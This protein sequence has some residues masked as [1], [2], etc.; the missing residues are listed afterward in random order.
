M[1]C[2]H[3]PHWPNRSTTCSRRLFDRTVVWIAT[4]IESVGIAIIVF[5]GLVATGLFL[6]R[7]SQTKRFT[8]SGYLGGNLP[9]GRRI[10]ARAGP[11]SAPPVSDL[12]ANSW[13]GA[14]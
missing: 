5:G 8:D 10:I 7:L 4:A 9:A 12:C 11:D 13:N 6:R 2:S 3:I 14:S 1:R